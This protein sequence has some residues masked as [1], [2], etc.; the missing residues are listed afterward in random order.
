MKKLCFITIL[1]LIVVLITGCDEN[2]SKGHKYCTRS[3]SVENGDVSL[4]Y[5]IYYTGDTLNKIESNE[6]VT[7]EDS[8]V[9]DTYENAYKGIHVNYK[10][11]DHYNTSVIRTDDSVTSI[12]VIDYDKVDIDRLIELEGEDDNIFENKIPKVSKWL[13]LGKKVGIKCEEVEE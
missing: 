13:E 11:L 3:G 1:L 8:S 7:S 10:G 9:L 2:K 12:I 5:N 4:N 6:K